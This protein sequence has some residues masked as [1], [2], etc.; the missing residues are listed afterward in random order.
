MDAGAGVRGIDVC[1][2]QG[3]IDWD[4]VAKTGTAFA[5]IKATDGTA[6]IDPQFQANWSGAGAAGLRRG[7]YHVYEPG[8]DPHQQAEHFLSVVQ[9]GPGDLPAALD[10]ETSGGEPAEIVTGIQ[11]WLAAVEQATGRVPI[12]HT[13]TSFWEGLHAV[14]FGRFPLWISELGVALPQVPQ[15]W[16]TWT[17]W[18]FSPNG[19]I[20][21]IETPVALNLFQGTLQAFQQAFHA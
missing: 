17:F 18:Q 7:A 8:V 1:H 19:S 16:E 15:G 5:F 13:N 11:A 20:S 21:G 2:Y 9:T 12:L 6:E 14:E 3:I 4:L 10:V